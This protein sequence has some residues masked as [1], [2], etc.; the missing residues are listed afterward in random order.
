MA[1]ELLQRYRVLA[2]LMVFC[3]SAFIGCSGKKDKGLQFASKYELE[4]GFT[5]AFHSYGIIG[6]QISDNSNLML[7][8]T[9]GDFLTFYDKN[10]DEMKELFH[11]WLDYL[12][13]F[14]GSKEA[15]GIL[16]RQ[17]RK[18]LFHASRDRKGKVYFRKM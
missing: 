5:V 2:I 11:T 12:Y 14:K 6:A 7:A 15:V 1:K 18:D 4:T 13:R 10:A 8:Y 17:G 3:L 9:N 16:I